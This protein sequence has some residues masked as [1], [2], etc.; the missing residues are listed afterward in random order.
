MRKFF[1]K[2]ALIIKLNKI[3]IFNTYKLFPLFHYE[4]F[5]IKKRMIK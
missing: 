3:F 5:E 1:I 2:I 4:E